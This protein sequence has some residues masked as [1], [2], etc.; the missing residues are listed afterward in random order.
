M[1]GKRLSRTTIRGSR[2]AEAKGVKPAEDLYDGLEHTSFGSSTIYK[3]VLTAANERQEMGGETAQTPFEDQQMHQHFR[4]LS[5][6]K[7][8]ENKFLRFF[9]GKNSKEYV[10]VQ[11]AVYGVIDGMNTQFTDD[12]QNNLELLEEDCRL[13]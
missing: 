6:F 13:M 3:N 2:D 10:R 8:A 12:S 4:D 5:D 1:S 11:N 7:Y 9:A